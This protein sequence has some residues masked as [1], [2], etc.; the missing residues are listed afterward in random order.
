M[1]TFKQKLLTHYNRV[2]YAMLLLNVFKVFSNL[3]VPTV[4]VYVLVFIELALKKHVNG[5]LVKKD[6]QTLFIVL[7]ITI[8]T[9][10]I[11]AFL[12]YTTKPNT[13][14]F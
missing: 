14:L 9:A 12:Y 5:Q 11:V 6:F 7:S 3:F 1:Q 2:Y 4:L 10:V 8:I 13:P